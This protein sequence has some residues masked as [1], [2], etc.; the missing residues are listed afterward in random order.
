MCERSPLGLPHTQNRMSWHPRVAEILLM[1]FPKTLR[2]CGDLKTSPKFVGWLDSWGQS[3]CQLSETEREDEEEGRA[4]GRGAQLRYARTSLTRFPGVCAHIHAPTH[5]NTCRACEHAGRVAGPVGGLAI[6][7]SLSVRCVCVCVCVCAVQSIFESI[8][9][10]LS[11]YLSIYLRMY[12]SI[13][14]GSLPCQRCLCWSLSCVCVCVFITAVP[15]KK[16]FAW[17]GFGL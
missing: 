16:L 14:S 17:G 11:I 4:G 8:L 15:M 2:V 3:F 6:L 13:C 10:Y 12:L 7:F 9:E 5:R 1:S